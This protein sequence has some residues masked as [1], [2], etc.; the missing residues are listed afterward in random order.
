MNR[1]LKSGLLASLSC[2]VL[3]ACQPATD[4]VEPVTEV[5]FAH[6]ASDLPVDPAVR[7]GQLENGMRFAIMPNE[8]PENVAAVRLVF[9]I[10]SLAEAE[11]QRGLAHFIEHMAFNGSTNMEE[12]DMVALLERFGLQFGPDTNAFTGYET[13][14]YQ[15]DLP[16]ADTET[17]DTA[18][19]LMRETASELTLDIEAI[20]RERGV[21]LSEARFRDTP[22]QRWNSALNRFRY[23]GTLVADRDPIGL[24]DVIETAQR[25]Q[26]ADYY[27]N[28]YIPGRAILVVTGDIDVADVESRIRE[29]FADWEQ[30]QEPRPDPQIGDVEQGRPFSVGYFYDPE[31][32]TIL[33]IDA[34]RPATPRS[35][36]REA[37]FQNNLAGLGDTILSRR[38]DTIVSSGVSPLLQAQVSHTT[39][40]QIADRASVLAVSSPDRWEEGLALVEQELRRALEHGFTQAELD[41]QLANQLSALESAADQA[42]TRYSSALADS[43]W[44]MWRSDMVYTTPQS[45][46]ERYRENLPNI[47]VE[48]VNAAFRSQWEGV[49]PLVFMASSQEIEDAQLRIRNAWELSANVPVDPPVE[50]GTSAFAYT[51]FGPAGSVAERSEIEDLDVVRVQ[52]ENGVALTYKYTDF[53]DERINVRVNFGAGSLEP[54]ALPAVDV[55]AGAVFVQSGLGEHSF[56]ELGR[57]L[58]GRDVGLN[59]GVGDQFFQFSASTT[60]DDFLTQMQLFAA[61]MTDPGW[62]PEGLARFQAVAPEVRRNFYSSPTGVLQAKVARML[63]SGDARYGNPSSA[64]LAEIDMPAIQGFLTEAL[65]NSPI[66]I[67]I[68][69]DI[70]EDVV[71]D[72]LSQTFGALP[73]RADSWPRYDEARQVAFPAANDR[74]VVL[75]HNGQANQAMVN[76]YWPTTDSSDTRLDRT[77]SLLR[78]VFD[79][80]LTERLREQDGLTYSAFNSDVS[81]DVYPD[82]GYLWVGVDV[83]VENLAQT[84]A[85]VDELAAAMASGDISEDEMLRARRPLLEQIEEA[86]QNNGSWMAWLSGSW[87]DANRLERIRTLQSDYE[88]ITVE[89][90][91][92]A[93]ETYLQAESA[94]RVSIISRNAAEPE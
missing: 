75:R 4:P 78:A 71:L 27:E 79:L 14:G 39:S 31:V 50:T 11:D 77:I 23:P 45:A 3:A 22:I 7:Y 60:P 84:Y 33:T 83:S 49:E 85:A 37:R 40:F 42:S 73:S 13:V 46:L 9:N 80:K 19:F 54:R 29:R 67:T 41:E 59:F 69:G 32:F 35:D 12:G 58:A 93:A 26:F 10:G 24:P 8:T 2:L 5:V 70:P 87:R 94:W 47:T 56:D 34:V 62:R 91:T 48:A 68:V 1:I 20:D 38:F 61:Y 6:E 17:L 53:S 18:L 43:I 36:S 76:T 82:Y 52:F 92:A 65:S 25:E 89:D 72:A 64:E 44:S 51:D 63:R 57:V 28:F 16:E 55:V 21:I 15:L 74:P 66:E 30:P 90:I 86:F 88:S 81:S